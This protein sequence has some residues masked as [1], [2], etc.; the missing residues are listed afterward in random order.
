MYIVY[1]IMYV[2]KYIHNKLT[3][4]QKNTH[5]YRNAQTHFYVLSIVLLSIYAISSTCN[6]ISGTRLRPLPTFKY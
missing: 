4:S 3:H 5:T 2:H 1:C 6:E